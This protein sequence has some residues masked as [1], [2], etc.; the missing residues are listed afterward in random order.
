MSEIGLSSPHALNSGDGCLP[1][2]EELDALTRAVTYIAR[3]HGNFIH[4]SSVTLGLE[5]GAKG[6][7]LEQLTTAGS[8]CG[9]SVHWRKLRLHEI[10]NTSLPCLLLL[11]DG[12]IRLLLAFNMHTHQAKLLDPD[13]M[14]RPQYMSLDVL[15]RLCSGTVILFEPIHAEPGQH[16]QGEEGKHWFWSEFTGFWKEYAVIVLISLLLSLLVLTQPLF[17]KAIYEQALAGF[18]TVPYW[19]FCLGLG[20]ALT[21]DMLL[22]VMRSSILC[23]LGQRISQKLAGKVFAHVQHMDRSAE[24]QSTD[25]YIFL[26]KEYER[27]R[28]FLSSSALPALL[29]MIFSGLLIAVLFMIAGPIA[30]VTTG[31]VP[32]VCLFNVIS[33]VSAEKKSGQDCR[34]EANHYSILTNMLSAF[35]ACVS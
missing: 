14:E 17:F 2:H 22:K 18:S 8:N 25:H 31:A 9:L 19:S 34:K 33:Q 30:W 1:M 5:L 35:I 27:F 10:P 16:Y 32:L 6:L 29:D 3:S 12:A 7:S 26:L 13:Q 21:M 20:L 24:T 11:H 23:T 4:A 28:D 15:R